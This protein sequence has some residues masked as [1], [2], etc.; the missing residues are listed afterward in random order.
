MGHDARRAR[1]A[2]RRISRL[3]TA[4]LKKSRAALRAGGTPLDERVHAARTAIKKTRALVRLVRSG[5]GRAR[6]RR[7]ARRTNRQLAKLARR[8][9]PL[10]DAAVAIITFDRLT[11]AM[12]PDWQPFL[13]G[14]RAQL[15][16]IRSRA[17]HRFERPACLRRLRARFARVRLRVKHWRPD[18]DLWDVVANGFKAGYTKA[19]RAM[20]CALRGDD[21]E[22]FHTWRRASK[23]HRHHIQ[24][25]VEHALGPPAEQPGTS[26]AADKLDGLD[27]LDGIGEFDWKDA[28]SAAGSSVLHPRLAALGRLDDLLGEEHDLTCL[29]QVIERQRRKFPEPKARLHVLR[30]LEHR[31]RLLRAEAVALGQHLYAQG[32][33]LFLRTLATEAPTSDRFIQG[34]AAVPGGAAGLD[35]REAPTSAST[36]TT[37]EGASPDS[38]KA[39]SRSRS[40]STAV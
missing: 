4:Q 8:I 31:R 30:A 23:A 21:A 3:A 37:S 34:G 38:R 26:S 15:D 7:Q 14:F 24:F 17:A 25:L 18:G 6:A 35:D 28:L 29:E 13:R 5:L 27:K 1:S 39:A 2:G 12:S 20:K 32:T 10:R 9:A 11:A 33:R 40:M 22:A 19:R 36:R 16:A